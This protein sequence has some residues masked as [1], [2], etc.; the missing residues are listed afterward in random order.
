[1]KLICNKKDVTEFVSSATWSGASTQASRTLEFTVT[2]SP[3]DRSTNSPRFKLGDKVI[4]H[5]DKGNARFLGRI[6]SREKKSEVGSTTYTARD[7]LHNLIKSKGSYKFKKKTAEYI[8]KA[9]LKD[10]GIAVGKVSRTRKKLKKYMPAGMTYYDI[11]QGVYNKA[12]RK[13][14]KKY[15]LVMSGEKLYVIVRGSIVKGLVINSSQHITSAGYT[16]NI[17]NMVNEVAIYNANNKRIGL[18]RKPKWIK[19]YGH[20]RENAT[21]D[22]KRKKAT[23]VERSQAKKQLKGAE[24]TANIEALGD[25]RC[26]SGRGIQIYDKASGMIGTYWIKS[27]SHKFENGIHT[28]SLELDFKNLTEAVQYTGWKKSDSGGAKNP[29][30]KSD[31]NYDVGSGKLGWPCRGTITSKFG[32]R[33]TGIAGASTFHEGLDIAA[34]IGTK[35]HAAESGTVETSGYSGGYG[36]LVVIKHG[37]GLKTYYGHNSV[38]KCKAGQS[39]KKGQVIALM[40]STGISSGSHCHFGVW[41]GGGFKDPEKYLE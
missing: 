41:D 8:T 24:K 31:A 32:P 39:V 38:L 20:Y 26:V 17:D 2:N 36:K 7:Y 1:M 13:T 4:W 27:D 14:G 18:V 15:M 30:E 11:I 40:G 3:Y 5:D 22:K 23:R 21:S 28:M 16:E 25:I 34:P 12:S 35:I 19:K 33:N 9:V 6:T 10:L 29:R 37:H